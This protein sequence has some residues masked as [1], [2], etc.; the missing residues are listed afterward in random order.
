[1]PVVTLSISFSV[2]AV[3]LLATRHPFCS[4]SG[5]V[6]ARRAAFRS[7]RAPIVFSSRSDGARPG[8]CLPNRTWERLGARVR[9]GD[10]ARPHRPV[11]VPTLDAQGGTSARHGSGRIVATPVPASPAAGPDARPAF[12]FLS[13][14]RPALQSPI[15]AAPVLC[16]LAC[17]SYAP[18]GAGMTAN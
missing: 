14:L 2:K 15:Q 6:C 16:L 1:M 9:R 8:T 12:K 7:P 13:R 11:F 17:T 3:S 5:T 4:R 18:E 10:R